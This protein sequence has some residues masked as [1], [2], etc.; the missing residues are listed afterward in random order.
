MTTD[1]ASSFDSSDY[2]HFVPAYWTQVLNDSPIMGMGYEIIDLDDKFVEYLESDGIYLEETQYTSQFSDI[3]DENYDTDDHD[4]N[5]R[6]VQKPSDMFPET[7]SKIEAAMKRLGG[8]V[9]PKVNWT[10]PKV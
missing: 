6:S 3:E 5:E 2:G 8:C 9:V 10:V 1:A 4:N 7:H